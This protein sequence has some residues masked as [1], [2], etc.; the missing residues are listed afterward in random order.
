MSKIYCFLDSQ[1]KVTDN[2]LDIKENLK[3][4]NKTTLKIK[5]QLLSGSQR[6]LVEKVEKY[7][8]KKIIH[9]DGSYLIPLTNM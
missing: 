1:L 4:G 3:L 8:L 6:K 9:T 7:N 5:K 2:I